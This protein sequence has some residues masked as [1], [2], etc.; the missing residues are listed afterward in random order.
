MPDP[1]VKTDR[2]GDKYSFSV[3]NL[4]RN[5]YQIYVCS[6]P[7]LGKNLRL[8][9]VPYAVGITRH[10]EFGLVSALVG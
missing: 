2:K 6:L 9:G 1:R 4:L 3:L 10:W 8:Y 7:L 5:V